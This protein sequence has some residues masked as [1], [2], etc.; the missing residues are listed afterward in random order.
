MA[1]KLQIFLNMPR[2]PLKSLLLDEFLQD[3]GQSSKAEIS[4]SGKAECSLA[5]GENKKCKLF[6]VTFSFN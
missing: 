5:I 3:G 4:M 1:S 2:L 6:G